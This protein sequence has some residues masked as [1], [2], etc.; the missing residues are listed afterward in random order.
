MLPIKET[1]WYAVLTSNSSAS[2]TFVDYLSAEMERALLEEHNAG[3]WD[4][5]NVARG[6]YKA[7][8]TLRD[9]YTA[10]QREKAAH[11]DHRRALRGR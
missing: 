8:E 3:T 6:K 7:L 1:A 9:N 11:E 4:A 10:E 2:A 5:V